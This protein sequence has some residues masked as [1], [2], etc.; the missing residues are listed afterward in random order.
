MARM[1]EELADLTRL[2]M[3]AKLEEQIAEQ[4]GGT[5]GVDSVQGT[6][7]TFTVRLPLAGT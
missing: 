2:R 6:G 7:S 1:L 4:H 3:G 5:I